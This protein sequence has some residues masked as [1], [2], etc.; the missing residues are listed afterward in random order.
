MNHSQAIEQL[1]SAVTTN[2]NSIIKA[3][4]IIEY[5]SQEI[6]KLKREICE[7]KP[8]FKLLI[9]FQL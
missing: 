1:A 6:A 5:Q 7:L 9:Q 8:K 2:G 4:E 3:F